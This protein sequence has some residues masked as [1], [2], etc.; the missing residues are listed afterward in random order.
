ME[1]LINS[2]RE[3]ASILEPILHQQSTIEDNNGVPVL[4][5]LITSINQIILSVEEVKNSDVPDL[6][7]LI[8]SINQIILNIEEVKNTLTE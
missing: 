4:P 3:K 8:T 2:N 1:I 6:P 5:E 7:E